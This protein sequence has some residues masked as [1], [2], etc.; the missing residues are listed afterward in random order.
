MKNVVMSHVAEAIAAGNAKFAEAFA[1]GDAAAIAAL[2]TEEG[3][4]LPPNAETMQGRAAIEAFWQ[5]PMNMGVKAV[6]LTSVEVEDHGNVAIE[7][8]KYTLRGEGDQLL[9]AGKYVVVWKHDQGEWRLHRDIWN[10]SQ[11]ASA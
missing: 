9:D 8:G 6:T 4:V 1:R 5:V 3:A 10:T 7:V 2:Y 11:P